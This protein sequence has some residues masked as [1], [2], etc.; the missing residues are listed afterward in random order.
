MQKVIDLIN[1]NKENN[2]PTISFEFF[3]PRTE[4]GILFY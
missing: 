4:D 2:K 1:N 3:P